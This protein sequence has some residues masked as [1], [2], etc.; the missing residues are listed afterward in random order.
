MLISPQMTGE[1]EGKHGVKLYLDYAVE[2]VV[3]FLIN[4][5]GLR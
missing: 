3:D 1:F 2:F 5:L 4:I